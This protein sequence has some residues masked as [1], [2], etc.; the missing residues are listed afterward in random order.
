MNEIET[1]REFGTLRLRGRIWWVRYKVNGKPYDES[2]GASDRRKAERL[3][4]RRQAELGLGQFTAPDVRRTTF[5]DVARMIRD[6]YA[7]NGRRS[8]ERLDASLKHLTLAFGEMRVLLITADRLTAYVR[9]RRDAGAAPAT[10]RNE[11]NAL[12]RAFRLAK[13]AG[14]MANVPEFPHLA[15]A[16]IR[17]GFFEAEDFAAVLAELPEDLRAPIEFAHLTGWRVPSE[18]LPL[19]WNRVD[20]TAGVVRLEPG[21]TKNDDGRTFPFDALPELA[22]LLRAQRE[23][24]TALEHATG[25]IV[26]HVFHRDG[27]PIRVFRRAWRSACRRAG[28]VGM[29]PHDLR[30]TAVRNLVRAGVPERVAMQ[31]TGHRPRSVFDRYNIVNERD[32]KE[33]VAK[34]A[35]LYGARAT[36][37]RTVL[38]FRG[39]AGGQ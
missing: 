35:T 4:A 32:L 12:R 3:L 17:T 9:E 19:T 30:R 29:I 33:G 36:S 18:V 37:A 6:D 14:K 27:E 5:E 38:P 26:R 21:T 24:T 23:R 22:A 13:R 31:L 20:F 15:V 2:S 28:L 39:A 7:A 34:L 25:R 10:I 8:T 16:N 1:R 11:L